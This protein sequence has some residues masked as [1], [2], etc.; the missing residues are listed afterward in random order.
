[1]H[2]LFRGILLVIIILTWVSPAPAACPR[3]I[4]PRKEFRDLTNSEWNRFVAALK[5]INTPPR[6]TTFDSLVRIHSKGQAT[7]G[8]P[9]FFP[10][11]RRYLSALE[12]KLQAQDPLV[13]VPYWGRQPG[14]AASSRVPA[15]QFEVPRRRRRRA[16]QQGHRRQLRQLDRAMAEE[17]R[18]RA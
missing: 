3:G 14:C 4:L 10:F 8:Q 13:T 1:M 15:F 18:S 5:A 16:S 7:H 9:M 12:R 11:H 17:T 2:R 6:P